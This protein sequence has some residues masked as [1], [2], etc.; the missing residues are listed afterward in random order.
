MAPYL[1]PAL[2]LLAI[3]RARDDEPIVPHDIYDE[4]PRAPTA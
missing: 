3:G 2:P 1:I 4:G